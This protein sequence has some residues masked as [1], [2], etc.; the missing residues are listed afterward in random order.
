MR[1]LT[2]VVTTLMFT[3]TAAPPACADEPTAIDQ[4]VAAAQI[5]HADA[6]EVREML[7][8]RGVNLVAV[9]QQ[10]EVLHARAGV[11]IAAMAAPGVAEAVRTPAQAAAL[12]RARVTAG[13]M[14]V[15]IVS[16][17]RLLADVDEAPAN[18]QRLRDKAAG[19]A[20]RAALVDAQM[21]QLRD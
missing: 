18:R 21:A 19:V 20:G 11:L 1:H 15:L 8:T 12:E 13:I 6:V 2:L 14:Q 5:V 7:G 4:L 10:V 17:T 3:L 9:L 16:K